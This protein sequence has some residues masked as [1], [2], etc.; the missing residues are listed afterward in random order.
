M[1][2]LQEWLLDLQSP[3]IALELAGLAL[4]LALAWVLAHRAVTSVIGGPRTLA[5]WQDYWGALDVT[6]T[7]E[8]EDFVNQLVSPGHP[9]TPGYNDPSY[10]LSA[11][12]A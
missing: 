12:R 9:S 7:Q 10:P 4:C 1:N 6:I 3:A 11:R 5:Q 2:E 8:D